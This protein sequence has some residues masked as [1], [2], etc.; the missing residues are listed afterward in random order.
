MEVVDT[1]V[2]KVNSNGKEANRLVVMEMVVGAMEVEHLIKRE[3]VAVAGA[4]VAVVEEGAL[5]EA[6]DEE[7]IQGEVAF[8][9]PG[10]RNMVEVKAL[11]TNNLMGEAEV[12]VT[13]RVILMRTVGMTKCKRAMRI[14]SKCNL[15][16][17]ISK[18]TINLHLN[19]H[20]SNL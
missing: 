6:R 12:E 16:A 17:T 19:K 1:E 14:A 18:V 5:E 10:N 9:S 13:N 11:D 8:K 20:Q 7:A 15:M 4:E 3:E 2:I